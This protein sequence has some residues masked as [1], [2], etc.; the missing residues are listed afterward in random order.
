MGW[1]LPALLRMAQRNVRRNWRH[2]IAAILSI[3]T[4]FVAIALFEGYL[5]NLAARHMQDF[6]R[7]AMYGDVLVQRRGA[8]SAAARERPFD[9]L[10]QAREQ[11]FL[12]GY[13]S[14]HA[15]AV[16][17]RARY[18]ELSGV[19]TTGEVNAMF[20]G[21]GYDVRE[22]AQLR[23]ADIRDLVAGKPLEQASPEAVLLARG[24]ARQLDCTLPNTAS[25]KGTAFACPSGRVQLTVTTETGQLNAAQPAVAGIKAVMLKE[26][27]DS[28]LYMPLAAAQNLLD[29]SGVSLYSIALKQGTPA[30]PFAS[31]LSAAAAEQGLELEA[32]P[33]RAHKN[34]QM[35]N[36]GLE[37]L[38]A[39]RSF[40]LLIVIVV[41]GSSVVVTMVKL[42]GERVREI[43]SLRALGFRRRHI[44]LL[45][46]L[47]SLLLGLL[48]IGV[49]LVVTLLLTLGVNLAHVEYKAGL[50]A[51]SIPLT[52]AYGVI[53]YGWASVLL[54]GI[55][56][57][58][59]L[60]PAR[61]ASRLRIASA[62]ADA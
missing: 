45:F 23:G 39:F 3:A 25:G 60:W 29:T 34:A 11:R 28:L 36:E 18:H 53:T 20:L 47:E 12:S 55:V 50:L 31:Q 9:Y 19:A 38:E 10:L 15:A 13:L 61:Q 2:S 32:T 21:L 16:R 59:A 1:S 7:R 24:L 22:G 52:I 4:G 26:L 58:A 8:S 40:V 49:G 56:L 37:L 42:V 51:E 33:W 44:L 43:G 62:L 30:D 27:D 41:A 35:L 48:A 5:N 54:L 46:A 14:D 17:T 6:A 57:V